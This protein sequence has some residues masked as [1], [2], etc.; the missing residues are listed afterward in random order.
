MHTNVYKFECCQICIHYMHSP[1]QFQN[2]AKKNKIKYY[3]KPIKK[4]KY[5]IFRQDGSN[6]NKI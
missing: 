3:C 1:L 6:N 4:V 2:K 5:Y